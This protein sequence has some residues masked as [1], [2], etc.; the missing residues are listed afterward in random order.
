MRDFD[1]FYD[2]GSPY[3]YLAATQLDGIERRTGAR[4]RLL[5]VTLGA[6]RKSLGRELPPPAQLLYMSQDVTSWA[7]KYGVTMQIPSVFPT[8]TIQSLRAC[9]A[10]GQGGHGDQAM[11]ALFAAYWAEGHDLADPAVIERALS[12][13]GLDGKGLLAQTETQEAKDG[14]R[15]NTDLALSR[16]VFGVPTFFVGARAFWG[17]DRLEFVEQELR[18]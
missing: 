5:P 12:A 17:N 16:G 6:I 18:R 13:A 10:A 15:K 8:K 14:L 9:V 2:L 1:F 11:H 3:S 7:Q 4:A